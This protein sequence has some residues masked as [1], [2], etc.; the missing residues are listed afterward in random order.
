MGTRMH[1]ALLN[2]FEKAT[3]ERKPALRHCIIVLRHTGLLLVSF[4]AIVFHI[5]DLASTSVRII[6]RAP[7]SDPGDEAISP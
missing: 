6:A 3:T 2:F 1:T 4:P 5:A 7:D